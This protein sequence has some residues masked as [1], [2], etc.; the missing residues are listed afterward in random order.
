MVTHRDAVATLQRF[1]TVTAR[2]VDGGALAF[3][4]DMDGRPGEEAA[5]YFGPDLVF[6]AIR[7]PLMD[8]T[9]TGVILSAAGLDSLAA[10]LKA[11]E[12]HT[13]GLHLVDR[14]TLSKEA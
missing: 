2:I 13:A 4:C 7:L 8:E 12:P 3:T 1:G 5:V 9:V 10:W 6:F 14:S 11:G